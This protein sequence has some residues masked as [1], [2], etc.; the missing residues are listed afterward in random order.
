[1]AEV[2][3][4]DD[5][6]DIGD[7]LALLLRDL[8]HG[9]RVARNGEEGLSLCYAQKP[10]LVLLDVEMPV[11]TGPQMALRI[12]LHDMGYEEVPIVLL[13][14]VVDLKQIAAMVGTPYFLAKPYDLESLLPVIDRA[15]AE[16]VP[17]V[18]TLR[19]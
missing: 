14:G 1:M 6:M 2:L 9:V 10:D 19:E 12:F 11:L 5:D 7:L 17:P 8:G 18:P 3:V 15:L 4:V 16:R 13:S